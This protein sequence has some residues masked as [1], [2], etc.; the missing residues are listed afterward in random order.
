MVSD[1]SDKPQDRFRFRQMH[2]NNLVPMGMQFCAL[3]ITVILN[4]T[5]QRPTLQHG[6]KTAPQSVQQFYIR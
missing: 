2:N 3:C 5:Q 1:I 6:T 4:S